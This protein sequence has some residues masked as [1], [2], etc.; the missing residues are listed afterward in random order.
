MLADDVKNLRSA[1]VK[2]QFPLSSGSVQRQTKCAFSKVTCATQ[3]SSSCCWAGALALWGSARRACA[4]AAMVLMLGAEFMSL[5]A[6]ELGNLAN[7]VKFTE[8]LNYSTLAT[9]LRINQYIS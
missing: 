2:S 6:A 8:H 1:I 5:F 7:P 4:A 9:Q 3:E